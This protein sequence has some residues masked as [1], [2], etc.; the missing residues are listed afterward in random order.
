MGQS[1]ASIANVMNMSAST[2]PVDTSAPAPTS[3]TEHLLERL[4]AVEKL[5]EARDKGILTDEEFTKLKNQTLG[6]E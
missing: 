4:A 6:L 2:A 3:S 5:A 1:M